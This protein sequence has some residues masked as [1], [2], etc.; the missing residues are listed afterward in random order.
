MIRR[1]QLGIVLKEESGNSLFD[2]F[3]LLGFFLLQG[4]G[5]IGLGYAFD[6][7]VFGGYNLFGYSELSC[8]LCFSHDDT[9]MKLIVADVVVEAMVEMVD[10]RCFG[11]LVV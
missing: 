2:L 4:F 11:S 9:G 5:L 1:T 10:G 6:A 3:G 8:F 7:C